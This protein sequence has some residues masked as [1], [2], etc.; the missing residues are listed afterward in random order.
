MEITYQFFKEFPVTRI[1]ITKMGNGSYQSIAT[2]YRIKKLIDALSAEFE[3]FTKLLQEKEALIKWDE[4]GKKVLNN[5][6]IKPAFKELY[7]HKFKVDFAPLSKE[8]LEAISGVSPREVE[9]LEMI[10][11]PTAMESLLASP[12]S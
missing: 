3:I 9:L 12:Q 7:D 4:S 8:E 6:E 2:S 10:A 11:D 1:L 5:E